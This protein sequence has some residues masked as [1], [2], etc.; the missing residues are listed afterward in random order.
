MRTSFP[1]RRIGA[2]ILAALAA[3]LAVGVLLTSS[4]QAKP[5][6]AA[7]KPTI[8]L[9]HGAWADS[10]SWDGEISRLRSDGYPV[11]APANPLRSLSGDAAYIASVLKTITG[12]IVLVGHSYGGAVITNAATGNPNVKAL[13][14]IDAFVPA[15]GESVLGLAA[16]YGSLGMDVVSVI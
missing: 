15:Q 1:M 14:Y 6:T 7:V 9:V 2:A 3:V 13:V 10:S 8:V 11:V 16:K 12:P 4:G 5:R